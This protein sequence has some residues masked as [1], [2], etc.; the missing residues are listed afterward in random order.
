MPRPKKVGRPADPRVRALEN[1]VTKLTEMLE[2]LEERGVKDIDEDSL[3]HE[4][5][6][7][8]KVD[9]KGNHSIV[10][11]KYSLKSKVGK[12]V[13][14]TPVRLSG[15]HNAMYEF[16]KRI[17]LELKIKEEDSE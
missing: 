6:G 11:I 2:E 9:G 7:V 15:E 13:E 3:N 8:V 5:F 10:R 4:T 17:R 16:N 12:I 1:K 14:M